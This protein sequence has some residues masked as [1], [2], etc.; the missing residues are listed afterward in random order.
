[1]ASTVYEN[2]AK[3]RDKNHMTDYYVA[4][5]INAG[6]AMFTFW[7]RGTKPTRASIDKLAEFFG[8]PANY[9]YEGDENE[10]TDSSSCA[11]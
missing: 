4:K 2:Y 8:V 6:R 11:C 1:M 7:R 10:E 5:K 9:F 3:L